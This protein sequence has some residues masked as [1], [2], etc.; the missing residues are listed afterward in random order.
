PTDS[1]EVS[2]CVAGF[3][4]AAR[5]PLGII[6]KGL[7][8]VTED[9]KRGMT[10]N[11]TIMNPYKYTTADVIY[12]YRLPLFLLSLLTTSF[13]VF[14]YNSGKKLKA[15][16]E[17]EK[18][19]LALAELASAAK[20]SFMSK[21]SH[22]IR[23]PLNAVIGY[24]TIARSE[25]AEA[26]DDASRRQA[27]MRVMDCLMKSDIAS[28]HLLAII[29][30]V[31]DMSA[32]ESGKIKLA[33][34]RFDFKGLIS[35]LTTIFYSQATAKGV[36]FEVV[37]DTLTEEWF[38]GDQVRTNQI[39]TNLLSN[40]MKFTPEGGTVRLTICQPEAA[41][42]AAH[43]HFEVADTGIGMSKDYL[44]HIWKP[45]EQADSSISRRFG[46]TG[47]GLSITKSLVD[48]LDGTISVES[49]PGD[50]STFFV[51]IT[52][53]RTEQP[54]NADTY[55]FNSINALVVDDDAST[56]DYLKLLFGRCGARCSAITSGAGAI[57]AFA[58]A[59]D[60]GE[61]FTLCLVRLAYA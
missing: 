43:I 44:E 30:D 29:N 40:A 9:E 22:E 14:K 42:N 15:A 25:M 7:S 17:Q 31:L 55:D 50:G 23:T 20:G 34:E 35:S 54:Q 52:F 24:N 16:Y 26:D 2:I 53:E 38:V 27:E 13:A 8:M 39:L 21:M 11:Y 56:C 37:L 41:E 10:M 60:R 5:V 47:L 61:P 33:R 51:D 46:G 58:A 57:E 28:K 6:N 4:D 36:E 19:A 3:T 59:K 49:E 32:I 45:F 18:A 12:K 48:L 1:E